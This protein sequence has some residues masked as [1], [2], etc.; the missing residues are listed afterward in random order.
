MLTSIAVT[1]FDGAQEGVL[2]GAITW[3][4]DR[5][6]DTGLSLPNSFR[7]ANTIWMLITLA[8]VSGL[9]WLGVAG[10]HTVRGS[11]SVKQLG[12]SFAHSLIPIALAYLVAHYFSASSL[13]GAGA[14]HLHTLRPARTRL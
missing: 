4:F 6:S 1:S 5:C 9:Y 14:V 12:R 11:P 3:T 13:P 7:V 2:S 8:V 10:M